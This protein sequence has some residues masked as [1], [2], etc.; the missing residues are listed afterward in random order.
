MNN[1]TGSEMFVSI[2]RSGVL[3]PLTVFIFLIDTFSIRMNT[4]SR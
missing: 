2:V 1:F 3:L 4:S